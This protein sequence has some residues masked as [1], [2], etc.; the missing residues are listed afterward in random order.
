MNNKFSKI[1]MEIIIIEDNSPDGTLNVAKTLIKIYDN[2][3]V[4]LLSRELL[5]EKGSWGWDQLIDR[6]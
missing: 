4:V 5:K 6:D 1:N 2:I 3:V